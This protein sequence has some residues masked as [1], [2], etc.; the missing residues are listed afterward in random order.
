MR[1]GEER[2]KKMNVTDNPNLT[3]SRISKLFFQQ[4]LREK[5]TLYGSKQL[6]GYMQRNVNENTNIDHP[7]S[8]Q[9]LTNKYLTSHFEAYA[10]AIREQEIGTKDPIFRREQKQGKQPINKNKCRLWKDQVKNI[11][12]N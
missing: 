8:T 2:L 10:C 5:E 6:H 4:V 3:P 9:W 11:T 7:T 12:R 1:V